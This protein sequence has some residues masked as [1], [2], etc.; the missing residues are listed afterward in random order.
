MK[1]TRQQTKKLRDR[2]ADSWRKRFKRIDLDKVIKGG[3]WIDQWQMLMIK[4]WAAVEK[5]KYE[6]EKEKAGEY[7]YKCRLR[8]LVWQKRKRG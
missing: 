2:L 3:R 6:G 7:K 1:N 5:K 4:E 8:K